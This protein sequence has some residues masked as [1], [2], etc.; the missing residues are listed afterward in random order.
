M[1]QLTKNVWTETEIRGCD[2]SMVFTSEGAV[3]IDT[4]QWITNLEQMIDFA[5]KECGSI[6][7][8]INT[9][10][11][12]D[13]IFGNHWL[14]KAGATIIA[15]E[16]IMDDFFLIPPAFNMETH[17]Y[18]VDVI[19]RQD[20]QALDRM[21]SKEEYIIAKPDITFAEK[22]TLKVGDHTFCLTHNPGHA[23]EQLTVY[24]PEER[25]AFTGDNLFNECQIWLHSANIDQLFESL[26]YI[27]SL[28]V[29][30][31]VPGHGPVQGKE[32]V[33]KNKQ[34]LYDW[35]SAVSDGIAKGWEKEECVE[36]INFADRCPVDIGQPECMDYIQTNNVRVA[37]D[38]LMGKQRK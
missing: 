11:H 8:L 17:D 3:F 25:V 36:R 10:G 28:D 21:P 16:K 19:A 35:L 1:Q 18:N 30:Y 2:P 29:D 14:K 38:Y 26:D 31:L 23:P 27:A 5:V 9:E 34:F 32:A 33:Y 20:P 4:A 24:V 7:Y 6:K 13:H 22:M 15:Q 37:Y 12:I